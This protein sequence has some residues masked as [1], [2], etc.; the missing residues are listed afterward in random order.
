MKPLEERQ[1]ERRLRRQNNGAQYA[2][3]AL[4]PEI[5]EQAAKAAEIADAAEA[6]RLKAKTKNKDAKGTW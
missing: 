1:A 6:A 3:A 5:A 2:E 4:S